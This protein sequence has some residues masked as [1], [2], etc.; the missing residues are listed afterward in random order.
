MHP[1]SIY[2]CV[3][4]NP[5]SQPRDRAVLDVLVLLEGQRRRVLTAQGGRITDYVLFDIIAY[6]R[7]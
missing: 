4:G 5:V 1:H 2:S 3:L 7:S 6:Y